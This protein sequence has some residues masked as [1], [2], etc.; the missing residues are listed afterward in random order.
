M[1]FCSGLLFSTSNINIFHLLRSSVII[2]TLACI[3]GVHKGFRQPS[4]KGAVGH[5]MTD[6]TPE[7]SSKFW[8]F[9]IFWF[10]FLFQLAALVAERHTKAGRDFKA[11]T[12]KERHGT[13]INGFIIPLWHLCFSVSSRVQSFSY[14]ASRSRAVA[15]VIDGLNC[16][17]LIG[18]AAAAAC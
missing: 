2:T 5:D 10:L 3:I 4:F 16:L 11:A 14:L 15:S 13:W 18:L 1:A 8:C 6:I 7:D 17:A 12:L 9:S